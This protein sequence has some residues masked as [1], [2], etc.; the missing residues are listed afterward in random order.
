MQP[1]E[2]HHWRLDI[3]GPHLMP[4][5]RASRAQDADNRPAPTGLRCASTPCIFRAPK[6]LTSD[7][8]PAK[9]NAISKP[10]RGPRGFLFLDGIFLLTVAQA[11]KSRKLR[12]NGTMQLSSLSKG[13][14]A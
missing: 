7:L 10:G 14:F 11:V 9:P 5:R 3:P 12:I 4:A 13:K 1:A 6:G 8:G 2:R